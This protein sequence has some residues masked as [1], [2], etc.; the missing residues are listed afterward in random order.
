MY[1]SNDEI[2]MAIQRLF[3]PFCPI[4]LP[5]NA[6]STVYHDLPD[7]GAMYSSAVMASREDVSRFR[8]VA[9]AHSAA[10]L[11]KRNN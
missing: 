6:F 1:H 4:F 10:K 7:G 3:A 11:Q 5:R 8:T 9:I 2:L